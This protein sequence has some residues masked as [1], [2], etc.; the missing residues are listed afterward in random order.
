MSPEQA[1]LDIAV[2]GLSALFPGSTDIG[3]F[4]QDILVGQ[5]RI[6]EVPPTHWKKEDY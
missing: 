6:T 5:D 1:P 2:V 4:W 3:G